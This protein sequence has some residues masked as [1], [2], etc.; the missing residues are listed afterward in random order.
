M[1]KIKLILQSKNVFIACFS[2]FIF[3]VFLYNTKEIISEKIVCCFTQ[4]LSNLTTYFYKHCNYFTCKCNFYNAYVKYKHY[5]KNI[6]VNS[7]CVVKCCLKL[8]LDNQYYK[9]YSI[10]YSTNNSINNTVS[11]LSK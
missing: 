7:N 1:Q 8:N 9:N 5:L 10:N 4:T 2:S 6:I 3:H 11:F